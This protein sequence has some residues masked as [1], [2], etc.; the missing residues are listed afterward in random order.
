[1]KRLSNDRLTFTGIQ[2]NLEEFV[3][4][5]VIVKNNY[6]LGVSEEDIISTLRLFTTKLLVEE[7]S[8]RSQLKNVEN[9]ELMDK[10][11]AP[12]VF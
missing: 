5:V 2:G 9:A 8:A 11:V 7:S 6:T 1:M 3:G 4:D 10:V 12:S